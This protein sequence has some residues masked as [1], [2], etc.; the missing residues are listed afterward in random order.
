MCHYYTLELLKLSAPII[1]AVLVLG[2]VIYAANKSLIQ[3]KKNNVIAARISWLQNLKENS[4]NFITDCYT[5]LGSDDIGIAKQ[6]RINLS[7]FYLL[8]KLNLNSDEDLPKILMKQIDN[9]L[10]EIDTYIA[11]WNPNDRKP[12]EINIISTKVV[13]ITAAILKIEWEV[14]KSGF[15]KFRNEN[16]RQALINKAIINFSG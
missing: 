12:G 3:V 6:K 9:L 7:K 16:E 13:D 11:G 14:T 2:G 1:S 8:I 15:I 4:A 5:I 10:A